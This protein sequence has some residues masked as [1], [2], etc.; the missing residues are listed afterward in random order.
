[1]YQRKGFNWDM[2]YYDIKHTLGQLY[3]RMGLQQLQYNITTWNK[4]NTYWV[5]N[6]TTWDKNDLILKHRIKMSEST[7][8]QHRITKITR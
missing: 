3:H 2:I 6:I 1:M 4:L 7:L 5:S 8:S